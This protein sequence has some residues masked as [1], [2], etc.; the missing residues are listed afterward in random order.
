MFG[1]TCVIVRVFRPLQSR[2]WDFR[3]CRY[4]YHCQSTSTAPLQQQKDC[5]GGGGGGGGGGAGR[6]RTRKPSLRIA[7]RKKTPDDRHQPT[8]ELI[9]A[10]KTSHINTTTKT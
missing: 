8:R 5:E 10:R 3:R 7:A 6:G 2:R 4:C 1:Y 9:S